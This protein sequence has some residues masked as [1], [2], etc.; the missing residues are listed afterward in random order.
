MKYYTPSLR[1]IY[2][3]VAEKNK[4]EKSFSPIGCAINDQ[5][6]L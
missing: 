1:N 2:I 4:I 5:W 6:P 3:L